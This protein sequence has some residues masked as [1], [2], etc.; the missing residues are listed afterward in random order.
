M[1][2]VLVFLAAT[3]SDEATV[4]LLTDLKHELGDAYVNGDVAALERIYTEDY[5]VI[6]GEGRTRTKADDIRALRAGDTKYELSR[7]EVTSVR[8]FGESAILVGRGEVKGTR[9]ES[10][11]HTTYVSTNVY[12]RVDG[13]WKIAAAHISGSR[14]R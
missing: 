6:D 2:L 9:G 8:L 7:Y 14:P 11:F 5:T 13:T 1:K 10:S 4:K 12:V 3:L